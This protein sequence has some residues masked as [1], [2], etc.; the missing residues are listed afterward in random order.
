MKLHLNIKYEA[1]IGLVFYLLLF[2]LF[3]AIY[4]KISVIQTFSVKL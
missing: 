4:T 2:A 1:V 3:A